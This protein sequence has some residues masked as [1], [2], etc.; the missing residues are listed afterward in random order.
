M[1]A[2]Q[3]LGRKSTI[4][5]GAALLLFVALPCAL[6]FWTDAGLKPAS[7]T[8]MERTTHIQWA[9]LYGMDLASSLAS[10]PMA[11]ALLSVL[12]VTLLP[13]FSIFLA[14]STDLR[15]VASTDGWRRLGSLFSARFVR[16]AVLLLL[17]H[18]AVAA[19]AVAKVG[20]FVLGFMLQGLVGSLAVV[21]FYSALGLAVAG[22]V[23]R[24]VWSVALCALVLTLLFGLRAYASSRGLWL[25]V[26]ATN[27]GFLIAGTAAELARSMGILAGESCVVL[28][29]AR[30]GVLRQWRQSRVGSV[31]GEV[32]TGEGKG[33]WV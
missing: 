21:G 12:S 33:A 13:F 1:K 24:P 25:L 29:L 7:R 14:R 19:V 26:P 3:L 15:A 17:V 16:V 20:P 4:V 8:F 31:N 27:D 9:Q 18:G 11:L 6:R 2:L 30:W 10:H 5:S 22:W 28:L 23:R 32:L